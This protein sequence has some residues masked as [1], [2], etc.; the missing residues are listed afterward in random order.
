MG[1]DIDMLNVLE[2]DLDRPLAW[3][4]I[5]IDSEGSGMLGLII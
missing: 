2:G 5:G 4:M 3:S 1:G